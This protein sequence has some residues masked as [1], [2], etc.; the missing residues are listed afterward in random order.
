[1]RVA[2]LET[3][4]ASAGFELEFDCI[5]IEALKEAGHEPILMVPEETIN[6][7]RFSGANS[8]SFWRENCQL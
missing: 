1:M 5:I 4:K 6:G 8:L 7:T 3:V 2:I